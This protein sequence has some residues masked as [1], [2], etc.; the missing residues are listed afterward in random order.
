ML[1]Q[2]MLILSK[3]RLPLVKEKETQVAIEL[4]F[5]QNGIEYIRE[6]RLSEEYSFIQDIPDFF[7]PLEGITIEVKIKGNAKKIY[8]QCERYCVHEKTKQ[9]ILVTNRSMGFPKELN[10]KPC[11]VINLGKG[12]L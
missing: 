4:L 8:R 5:Q 3:C 9:L 7:I 6:Y 11:Y 12:W 1:N 2:I 10:G